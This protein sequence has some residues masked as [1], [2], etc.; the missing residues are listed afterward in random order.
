MHARLLRANRDGHTVKLRILNI[1]VYL[2]ITLKS[3][4]LILA[5]KQGKQDAKK[6]VGDVAQS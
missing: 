1:P 4:R 6:K 3:D 2:A 5:K